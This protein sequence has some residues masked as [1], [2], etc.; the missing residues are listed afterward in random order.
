M[1]ETVSSTLHILTYL[2][3]VEPRAVSEPCDLFYDMVVNVPITSRCVT[4]Q[5]M[6]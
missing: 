6:C 3:V 5:P 1:P 4:N 2:K